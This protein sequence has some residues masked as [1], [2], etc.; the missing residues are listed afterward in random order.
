MERT[1]SLAERLNVA[2]KRSQGRGQIDPTARLLNETNAL[3]AKQTKTKQ[4][5]KENEIF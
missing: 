3:K 1:R 4:E 5:T 2:C